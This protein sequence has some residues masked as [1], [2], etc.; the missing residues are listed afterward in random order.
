MVRGSGYINN[1][2]N[3]Y[4]SGQKTYDETKIK[5]ENIINSL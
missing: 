3:K 1:H 2:S 5:K 4:E